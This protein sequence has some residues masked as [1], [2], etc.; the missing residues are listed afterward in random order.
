[1]KMINKS[2]KYYNLSLITE[3]KFKCSMRTFLEKN[4]KFST[5]EECLD[6]LKIKYEKEN[7]HLAKYDA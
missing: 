7:F 3:S 6:H 5:L 2:L 1:M 4:S